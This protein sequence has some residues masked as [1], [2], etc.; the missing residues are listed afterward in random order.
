M[1]RLNHCATPSF[2]GASGPPVTESPP[3]LDRPHGCR[4]RPRPR[5]RSEAHKQTSDEQTR[6]SF[7]LPKALPRARSRNRRMAPFSSLRKNVC[8]HFNPSLVICLLI[9][10]RLSTSQEVEHLASFQFSARDSHSEEASTQTGDC[11]RKGPQDQVLGRQR[12]PK[13][14]GA[15]AWH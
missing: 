12:L 15:V 14:K 11:R 4:S 1:T 9:V 2:E 13:A 10:P 8:Q 3:S 6:I 5:I 7:H